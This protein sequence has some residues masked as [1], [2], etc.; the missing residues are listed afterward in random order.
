LKTKP[1]I[2][3]CVSTRLKADI[4]LVIPLLKNDM[5]L[6]SYV[7]F[8]V[9]ETKEYVLTSFFN[10]IEKEKDKFFKNKWAQYKELVL[11]AMK[12]DEI[13]LSTLNDVFKNDIDVVYEKLV[14]NYNQVEHIPKRIKNTK[15]FN[16]LFPN[17][18]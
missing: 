6:V 3:I 16:L 7:H 12:Y 9:L 14:A 13:D 11:M 10:L 18:I 8:S 2:L 17:N 15:L 1:S 4:S 5:S